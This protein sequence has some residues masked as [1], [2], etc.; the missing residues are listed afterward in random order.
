MS[1]IIELQANGLTFTTVVDGPADGPAVILL[2]GFPD[3]AAT[4]E[5]LVDK[6]ADAGFRCLVPTMRG[7]EP[8]SQPHDGDYSLIALAADVAALLDAAEIDRAHIIGHDWGA[9]VAYLVGSH[10]GE[11]CRSVTALAIPPLQRIPP[12]VR[13]VPR[14]LLL[15]WYM[16]FFQLRVVA[17]RAVR[18]RNWALL[19]WLWNRWSPGVETPASVIATF[20][21]PGVLTAALAYYRQ[22]ATPPLLLGLRTNAAMEPKPSA[23][24]VLV[25]HGDRDGCMDQRL[26][27]HAIVELDHPHGVRHELVRGTGHFLHLEEPETVANTLIDW[28][29]AHSACGEP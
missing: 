27:D 7:Y 23:V 14:Q 8:S 3:N 13:K 17:D 9:V 15:S 26:F 16:T 11:R 25:M 20:E 24:P 6:L 1:S 21:Q 19:R 10:H 22:N 29:T 18:A 4:F 28:L 12:A 5:R 2:H